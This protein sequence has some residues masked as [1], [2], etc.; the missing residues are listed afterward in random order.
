MVRA[1][2]LALAVGLTLCAGAPAWA[3]RGGA[4]G[5]VGQPADRVV[6]FPEVKPPPELRGILAIMVDYPSAAL[7]R[8]EVGNV[9]F[10]MCVNEK[11]RARDIKLVERGAG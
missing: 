4:S 9:L 3:Q 7:R 11:G 2:K 5:V 1:L 6:V 8:R 10:S